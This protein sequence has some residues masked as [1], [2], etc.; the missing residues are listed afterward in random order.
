MPYIFLDTIFSDSSN[1]FW[2][3][4]VELEGSLTGVITDE[5]FVTYGW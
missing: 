4:L 3:E 2:F 5:I 1:G